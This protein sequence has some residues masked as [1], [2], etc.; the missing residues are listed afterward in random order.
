MTYYAITTLTTVGFGDYYPV[1][2]YERL[3]AC[4]VMF[5]GYIS[6]SL[7]QGQ[8]FGMIEKIQ[9]IRKEDNSDGESLDQFIMTLRYG[10]N[11]GFPLGNN[12]EKKIS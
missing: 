11:Y 8:L 1:D 2:S 4:F 3:T 7:M 6:F 12:C 5:G 9:L 10:Y